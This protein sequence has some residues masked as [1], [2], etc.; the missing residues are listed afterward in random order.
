MKTFA[1]IVDPLTLPEWGGILTYFY[2]EAAHRGVSQPCFDRS[3]SHRNPFVG[4]SAECRAFHDECSM[5]TTIAF[6]TQHV[7]NIITRRSHESLVG[8]MLAFLTAFT[9]RWH[10]NFNRQLRSNT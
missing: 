10:E 4:E 8:G 1:R 9:V 5:I 7:V 6:Q 3:C 2:F